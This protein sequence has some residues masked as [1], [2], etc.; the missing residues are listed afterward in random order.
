MAYNL[1]PWRKR[2]VLKF[3][4]VGRWLFGPDP[5]SKRHMSGFLMA[6][7]AVLVPLGFTVS[8][9]LTPWIIGA[10]VVSMVTGYAVANA[11][12]GQLTIEGR[13]RDL[14][15]WKREEQ[16]FRRGIGALWHRLPR[17]YVH[18]RAIV[19]LDSL[20]PSFDD[21]VANS[22]LPGEPGTTTSDLRDFLAFCLPPHGTTPEIPAE[23]QGAFNKIL[24]KASREL[25]QEW[26]MVND[27]LEVW[28]VALESGGGRAETL[29][30]IIR[31]LQGHHSESLRLA[32]YLS[33]AHSA[34]VGVTDDPDSDFLD[35]IWSVMESAGSQESR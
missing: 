14:I 12:A 9:M 29:R 5:E 28:D 33:I 35:R 18:Y 16:A 30:E 34:H 20:P 11:S 24:G 13:A 7:G 21:L 31:D 25:A 10:G 27:I 3:S 22:G 6:V 4:R 1:I 15:E 19:D 23:R 2:Q 17:A 8:S 26:E 32:R